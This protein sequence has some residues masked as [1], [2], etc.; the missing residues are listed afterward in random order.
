MIKI[1]VAPSYYLFESQAKTMVV[2]SQYLM[3]V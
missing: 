3:R 1:N 2:K